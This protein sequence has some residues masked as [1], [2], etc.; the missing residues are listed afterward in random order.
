VAELT[1]TQREALAAKIKDAFYEARDQGRTMHEAAED[2]RIFDAAA[3]VIREHVTAALDEIEKRI[4]G[5]RDGFLSSP[6]LDPAWIAGWHSA[7][8]HVAH[9]VR[10]YRQ[11]QDR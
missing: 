6:N 4:E 3:A 1:D 5:Q 8:D 9:V 11:E 7:V 10:D 2:E